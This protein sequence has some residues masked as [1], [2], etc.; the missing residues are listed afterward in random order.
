MLRLAGN[1]RLKGSKFGD[2]DGLTMLVEVLNE[3]GLRLQLPRELLRGHV[4]D[5]TLSGVGVRVGVDHSIVRIFVIIVHQLVGHRLN[6]VATSRNIR[7]GQ[8]ANFHVGQK[9]MSGQL[10]R[11]AGVH[12]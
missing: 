8:R 12:I 9:S 11:H 3:V 5:A 1:T 4:A 2:E 7:D 6:T 10:A